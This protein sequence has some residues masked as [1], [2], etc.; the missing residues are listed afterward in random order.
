[1]L[2]SIK[3]NDLCNAHSKVY[4][5]NTILNAHAGLMKEYCQLYKDKD[6]IIW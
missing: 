6:K 2:T 3:P 5:A 1:M 4:K